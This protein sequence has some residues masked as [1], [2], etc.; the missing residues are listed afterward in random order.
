MTAPVKEIIPMMTIRRQTI[1]I[2]AFC[3][4]ISATTYEMHPASRIMLIV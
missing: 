3:G 4:P 2:A 1:A